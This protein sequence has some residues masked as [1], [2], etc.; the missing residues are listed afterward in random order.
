MEDSFNNNDFNILR[1]SFLIKKK[2]HKIDE[3][4]KHK[5][6]L[7]SNKLDLNVNVTNLKET[8]SSKNINLMI[9]NDKSFNKYN[10]IV[11]NHEGK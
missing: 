2:L 8:N 5:K 6:L 1:K 9:I 4:K 3:R 10:E 11:Q 7:K